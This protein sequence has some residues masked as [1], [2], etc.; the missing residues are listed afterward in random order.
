MTGRDLALVNDAG[1]TDVLDCQAPNK[2]FGGDGKGQDS[3][4][5]LCSARTAA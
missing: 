3:P 5:P 4:Y 1:C 2:E